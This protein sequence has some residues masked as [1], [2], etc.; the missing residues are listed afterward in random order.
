[1]KEHRVLRLLPDAMTLGNGL[2]GFLAVAAVAGF[3]PT[4]GLAVPYAV[5]ALV[6]MGTVLDALDGVAARYW[7]STGLGANLDAISDALTFAVAPALLALHVQ[8][9]TNRPW[10]LLAAS[11]LVLAGILRLARNLQ[12]EDP[13]RFRGVPVSW[14]GPTLVI[15][16]LIQSETN[17]PLLV[18]LA[19]LLAALNVSSIHYPKTS[20]R[21]LTLVVLALSA[22]GLVLVAL[23]VFVPDLRGLVLWVAAALAVG[24]F[25][26]PL[27]LRMLR[28]N[29][30]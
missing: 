5:A 25:L 19:L 15:A 11:L 13:D 24:V 29:Q 6:G 4:S 9:D 7:G 17:A 23:L 22:V 2:A 14:S 21:G 16:A 3:A 1:M 28:R 18:P 8:G 12:D 26:S 20:G 30:T 10:M 27:V